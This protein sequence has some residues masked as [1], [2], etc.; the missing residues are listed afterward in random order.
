[1]INRQDFL[2]RMTV[3]Y[4]GGGGG[5]SAPIITSSAP[6]PTSTSVEV[7]QAKKDVKVQAARRKGI[8]ATILAGET[9]GYKNPFPAPAGG[10]KT[11]L[12]E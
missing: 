10:G 8:A 5:S 1:M 6:P 12:G 11:L 9:G 4:K 3:Y 7:T 2:S